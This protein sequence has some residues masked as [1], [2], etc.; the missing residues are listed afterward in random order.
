MNIALSLQRKGKHEEAI[1]LYEE[2]LRINSANPKAS[3]RIS[4][5]REALNAT[6]EENKSPLGPGEEE[7]KSGQE[8][9]GKTGSK[10]KKKKKKAQNAKQEASEPVDKVS[11]ELNSAKSTAFTP[12]PNLQKQ[13]ASTKYPDLPEG[14]DLD[15]QGNIGGMR[16]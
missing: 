7:K 4:K 3:Y 6:E 16:F 10:N 5:S 11:D 15:L 12:S 14:F 13:S 1:T 9:N 2:V 8:V